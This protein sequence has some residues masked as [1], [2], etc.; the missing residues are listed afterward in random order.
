MQHGCTVSI[1]ARPSTIVFPCVQTY[2]R[3]QDLRRASVSRHRSMPIL[4]MKTTMETQLSS[5]CI[6]FDKNAETMMEDVVAFLTTLPCNIINR[7]PF[8]LK[9]KIQHPDGPFTII[10][11]KCQFLSAPAI[12]QVLEWRWNGGDYLLYAS[13]WCLYKDFLRNNT[14][15]PFPADVSPTPTMLNPSPD[16]CEV[17]PLALDGRKRTIDQV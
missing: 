6:R 11:I 14:L 7:E 12:G 1:F 13:V 2:A 10:R 5:T 15:P 4:G 3:R 8:S 16:P 17:P 9:A